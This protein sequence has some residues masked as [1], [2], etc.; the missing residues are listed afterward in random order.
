MNEQIESLVYYIKWLRSQGVTKD[1]LLTQEDRAGYVLRLIAQY[2]P[3]PLF[4][5]RNWRGAAAPMPLPAI[6]IAANF[7]NAVEAAY[8]AEAVAQP[9]EDGNRFGRY[10]Q[11]ECQT[12]E[13]RESL[14]SDVDSFWNR[15]NSYMTPQKQ[16]AYGLAVGRVQSGKTRNYIGLMF[17]AIDAGYNTVIILTSK[18]S[19]LAVQTH[20]RVEKWFGNDGLRVANYRALTRVRQDADG[21]ETGVEWL[22]G[23]FVANQVQVGVIIKNESG[24]L[25][26]V[27]EWMDRIG[28]AARR[29]MK[30]LFIDDESDSAT[31]NT[32][33]VADPDICCAEDVA[34]LARMVRMSDADGAGFVADWMENLHPDQASLPRMMEILR[35]AT[36]RGRFLNLVRNNDEFKRISGLNREVEIGDQRCDLFGLVHRMFDH[37]ATRRRPLNW[38]VLSDFFNYMYGV[39]QERS[40]INRSICELVGQ[41]DDEPAIFAYDKMVYAGYTATPFANMLNEDPTKDPLCPDCIKPLSTNSKYFGLNRIYGGEGA[42]CNMDIVRPIEGDEYPG[43]VQALQEEPESIVVDNA[44]TFHREH[45]FAEEGEADDLHDV[46]WTSIK[47]AVKWAFCTAA[48]RRVVRLQGEHNANDADIKYRW[49]TMLFNLSHLSNQETGVQPVQQLLLQRYIAFVKRPENRERFIDECMQVWAEETTR[50]TGRAFEACCPGYGE[51]QAYP[52]A[53]RVCEELRSWFIERRDKVQVIQMN[54]AA[55]GVE[56]L[57]YNDPNCQDGDVLWFV[58]GGNAISRGLTLEGLTVSYYDRIKG[59]TSVD[60][61]TQMGRWFGYRPG[62]E[63]LPR[64]WMTPETIAE[65]MQICRIEESLH[66]ELEDLYA[67]QEDADGA[68]RYPSIREGQNIASIRYFG[69]RLSGR[70]AN[71]AEYAGATSKCVFECVRAEQA[72]HAF[73]VVRR[74]CIDRGEAFPVQWENPDDRHARHRLFWRNTPSTDVVGVITQLKNEYFAGTSVFEAE[75]LLR[76]L[77]DY[78]GDWN[79]VVG[80]PEANGLAAV[81]DDFFDGYFRRNNPLRR[82]LGGVILLGR[83]QFTGMALLARVPNQYIDAAHAANNLQIG[84][85]RHVDETYSQIAADPN[86]EEWLLNPTLLIDFVNG[87]DGQAYVQAAFYWHGHT[88]ESFFRAVVRPDRPEVIAPVVEYLN[89]HGYASLVSLH[90]QFAGQLG[91]IGFEDFRE[92]LNTACAQQ[93]PPIALVGETEADEALL[94]HTVYY[95]TAWMN[96]QNRP[97]A[98]SCGEMIGLHLY[99]RVVREHWNWFNKPWGTTKIQ[100]INHAPNN[101]VGYVSYAAMDNAGVGKVMAYDWKNGIYE[102][103]AFARYYQNIERRIAA[104]VR[105]QAAPRVLRGEDALIEELFRKANAAADKPVNPA[106]EGMTPEEKQN[107]PVSYLGVTDRAL[108]C[109][110]NAG[111]AT[112]GQLLEKTEDELRGYR[113]FGKL[114]LRNI[115]QQLEKAG[116]HLREA[117]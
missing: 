4:L 33:S 39:Q 108:T 34:R 105:Q 117:E 116:L 13:E 29:E 95:S 16:R 60:A 18:S 38:R 15:L 47:H 52:E 3:S 72:Q 28:D 69:R 111:I 110:A 71:G 82:E 91:N 57:N 9:R 40:R 112:I 2:Q 99:R 103:P 37:R 68:V 19:R 90:H 23:Q 109:L 102:W 42:N 89:E 106:L 54:S 36:T 43:W 74:F 64:I 22:G 65:M 98:L 45:N 97:A 67:V 80:N 96:G 113:N 31:P 100:P 94:T 93:N 115:I 78:P 75:G 85:M 17:K 88:Q 25:S 48:A 11:G 63:L 5:A 58:C 1:E 7:E 41:S 46:E 56:Q 77:A 53:E 24:H 20:K 10:V 50:F 104:G 86:H 55:A 79:V 51:Y 70:D 83:K 44:E 87:D 49:T 66:T 59:T 101:G 21:V 84:S 114:S 6:D 73:D 107:A 62:Y 14:V 8:A 12:V 27:R 76:E 61:I 81:G 26:A 32:N 92:E 30:L 35:T